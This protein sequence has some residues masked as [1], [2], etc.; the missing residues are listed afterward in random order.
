MLQHRLEDNGTYRMMETSE[1]CRTR[2]QDP[3]L[4]A[5]HEVQADWDDEGAPAPAPTAIEN[6]ITAFLGAMDHGLDPDEVE[7]DVLGG[8]ALRF[9]SRVSRRQV[10]VSCLNNGSTSF[11]MA[12]VS[13]IRTGS[14]EVAPFWPEIA[15]FLRG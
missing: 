2:S 6:A 10:W 9:F 12:D 13:D 8:V 1:P 5:L 14:G 4:K 3:R 11:I 7:P 15:G